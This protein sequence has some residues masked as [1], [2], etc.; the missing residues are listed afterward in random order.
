[1]INAPDPRPPFYL[2]IDL[3]GTNVKSG[4]V[5]DSGRPI[6]SVS[7]ETNAERGP[8]VG[9]KNL[10]EAGRQ[11]VRASGL[12][13]SEIKGVGLG[14]PGTMDIDAGMLL[15]PPNLPGW[16]D[17]PIRERLAESLQAR[18]ILQ[19]D[20]NAAAFGEYWAGAGRN[21]K[22][23]VMFTLGTG[24]GCGIV[25]EG[26]IL[27]GRHSHGAECG[28]IIIQME[29]GRQC[30]C[31]A[32]GHLEG[33]ASATALV[34]RA[35]EGLEQEPNSSLHDPHSQGTLTSRAI[36]EAAD[37]GDPLAVR[38]M[39]ETARYLAVGAVSLMHTIDPDVVLFGGGMIAAGQGFLN[40][41]RA[42]VESLAFPIP[43][44]KTR[45]SYAEL[46]GDAGFIGA[47]GCARQA[48]GGDS[49]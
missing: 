49:S 28:H 8:E 34:K 42:D 39:R 48:F 27:Q 3:G 26:R 9:I 35:V 10:S 18:T 43:A 41:I 20:A 19:N 29:G 14:S 32:Y 16:N 5:D 21:T 37:R 44:E 30:S 40:M 45:L 47:A 22:S 1:M 17:F 33:Y 13:W 23:L 31:G 15:D 25:V 2:G 36:A 7:V 24:I 4:V 11:A 6:S 38:L 12:S 46:G